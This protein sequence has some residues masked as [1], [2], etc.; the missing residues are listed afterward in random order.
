MAEMLWRRRLFLAACVTGITF[1]NMSFALIAPFFPL[2]GPKLGLDQPQIALVFAI[3][4]AAQLVASPLAGPLA[5]FC[6]RRRILTVGASLLAVGGTCFGLGSVLTE[7]SDAGT[8][9]LMLL[10]VSCRLLQGVGSAL[11]V[12]CLFALLA[13]AFPDDQGKVMGLA[14]MAGGLGWSIVSPCAGWL[15]WHCKI[16]RIVNGDMLTTRLGGRR[17]RSA[18]CCTR[19]AGSSSRSPCSARSRW[20]RWPQ[21]CCSCPSMSLLSAAAA[22]RLA[23]CRPRLPP[24]LRSDWPD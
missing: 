18:G 5:T 6:G 17:R 13:D 21:S 4:S 11:M 10:L 24:A 2:E 20:S 15:H 16:S 8:N 19:A 9:G 3:M 7:H 22:R 12:T 1:G 14:E 23:T